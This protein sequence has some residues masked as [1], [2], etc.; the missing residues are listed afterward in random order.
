MLIANVD[1]ISW[2][3]KSNS[4]TPG[5]KFS[6]SFSTSRVYIG[7]WATTGSLNS[8]IVTICRQKWFLFTFNHISCAQ[9]SWYRAEF[10]SWHFLT[11]T[12]SALKIKLGKVYCQNEC[13]HLRRFTSTA[14]PLFKS[15]FVNH[16]SLFK[17]NYEKKSPLLHYFKTS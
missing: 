2:W 8:T 3:S 11:I 16:F 14:M 6:S 17:I 15:G 10:L 4:W 12:N 13:L 9:A 7:S 1:I 5:S